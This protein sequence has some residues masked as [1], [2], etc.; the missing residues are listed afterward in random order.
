M[1]YFIG[2]GEAA[3]YGPKIDVVVNDSLGREWQLTTCQLDFN[4]PENFDLTY[5]DE[6]GKKMRPAILHIAIL[7]SLERFLGVYIEHV[8]GA[9]PLWLAPEQAW[10]LPISDDMVSYAKEIQKK[11]PDLRLRVRDENETLGKKIREG[12]MQ[13]IPYLLIVGNKEKESGTVSVRKRGKGDLGTMTIN[14][15]KEMALKEL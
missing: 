6:K 8:G 2:E 5:T 14:S 13:K 9:F 11:L 4:Q 3:F 10:I 12:E 7:G 1:E 15:F